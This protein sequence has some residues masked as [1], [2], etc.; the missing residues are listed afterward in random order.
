MNA[1]NVTGTELGDCLKNVS[2]LKLVELYCIELSHAAR[3][4]FQAQSP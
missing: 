2:C 3:Y 1:H 4:G